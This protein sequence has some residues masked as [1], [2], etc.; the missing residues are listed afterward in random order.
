MLLTLALALS[1]P[2][3]KNTDYSSL[4]GRVELWK[5]KA[6][7]K[8]SQ[9][10]RHSIQQWAQKATKDHA[11]EAF[12]YLKR[13]GEMPEQGVD[14]FHKDG[15]FYHPTQLGPQPEGNRGC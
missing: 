13:P 9:I 3:T 12:N 11:T 15:K 1:Q 5:R 7:F 14:N 6:D 10:T 4:V 2:L 8:H